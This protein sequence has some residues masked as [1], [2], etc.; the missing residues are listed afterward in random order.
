[1]N[2]R[3]AAVA[4][5]EKEGET[6][7]HF[8]RAVPSAASVPRQRRFSRQEWLPSMLI[9][10]C[11]VALWLAIY[12]VAT[13]LRQDAS[14]GGPFSFA[15][16]EAIQLIVIVQSLL[17][18]GGYNVK[19]EMRGLAYT[20]EHIL[21]MMAALALS[22]LLIYSAATFDQSMRPSRSA[23][24]VSFL[25]FTPISVLYR[26]MTRAW[27]ANSSAQRSF[28]VIGSGV[29]AA[30]FY[31]A[32][33]LS[34]NREQLEFADLRPSR[35]GTPVAG[36]GSPKVT[37]DLMVKLSDAEN[38]YRGIILTEPVSDFAPELLERLIRTQF[39]RTRV[40]TLEAFYEAHWR[41]V[42]AE[43]IDPFWPLQVGFQLTQISPYH[44]A[45]RIFDIVSSLLGLIV[46][47]PLLFLIALGVLLS[48]GRPM[49]FRQP[50]M[51]RD[52]HEFTIYKFR[53]MRAPQAE[54]DIY[55][56]QNDARITRLG[57]WLRKLRLDE[58]PQLWNVL[59]G[60]LSLIGPRAEWV[61]CV[62][63]YENKIPFCHY[64]HLVKPGITGWAQVNYPYGESDEDAMEKLKYDL[65]Y[66][67]NYSL[68]LDAM[69]VLK[70]IHIMLFG[71]GQ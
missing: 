50:R 30:K 53:T 26:R 19:N 15:A 44:Y 54:D 46:L 5:P 11:D 41:Q 56:Q 49:I 52:E 59:R 6:A 32:Y 31:E 8:L 2:P 29:L 3:A 22:A 9:L 24:L 58:L 34:P 13:L 71:R 4:L 68:K 25:V 33:R 69:I 42:P 62:R 55:A 39:Q 7:R 66:I 40:Y 65:Y 27:V 10:A 45:K 23:I 47:S 21:A 37:G 51:G 60:D 17:I 35:V 61:E 20:A 16:I 12:G 43:F 18:M 63:R 1:M 38:L 36:P 57:H 14:F 48:S 67:R 28:L 70:T 64:R